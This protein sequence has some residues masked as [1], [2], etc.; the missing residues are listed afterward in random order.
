MLLSSD[1]K[2]LQVAALRV[3]SRLL[4]DNAAG[5]RRL[6]QP[7]CSPPPAM[8]AGASP[9]MLDAL[10]RL[11]RDFQPDTRFMAACCLTHLT[12]A[13]LPAP[14]PQESAAAAPSTLVEE[15]AASSSRRGEEASA[16]FGGPLRAMV[17]RLRGAAAA[18][19]MLTSPSAVSC[20]EADATPTALISTAA[21]KMHR[22]KA[23]TLPVLLR[24]LSEQS[25]M[26]QVPP[27]LAKLIE[28][29]W[30]ARRA[31]SRYRFLLRLDDNSPHW[32]NNSVMLLS[33]FPFERTVRSFKRLLWTLTPSASWP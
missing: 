19:G 4:A 23:V 13:P 31:I 9:P 5:C 10:L 21:D 12:T 25:V 20:P 14:L 17:T 26:A 1:R 15:G 8:E 32:F 30:D 18:A 6:L 11:L 24:L 33:S 7:S 28:F 29:R 27:V 2:Q 3:L 22:A 16:A